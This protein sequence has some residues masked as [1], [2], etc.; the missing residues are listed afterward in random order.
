MSNRNWTSIREYDEIIFE[1]FEGIA[2]IS[3]NRPRYRNA[4]SPRTNEE[5]LD[6]FRICRENQDIYTVILTGVGDKAFCSG[7]DQNLRCR[8]L[9]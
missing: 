8:T 4:F 9:C 3:I 2:K 5:M 1:F 7:G 6:A